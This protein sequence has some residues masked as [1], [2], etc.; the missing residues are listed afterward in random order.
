MTF[1]HSLFA[2]MARAS[3]IDV[4]EIQG[5]S[6]RNQR[7]IKKLREKKAMHSD[8][9]NMLR[10]EVKEHHATRSHLLSALSSVQNELEQHKSSGTLKDIHESVLA[11]LELAKTLD[12]DKKVLESQV[13]LLR[14]KKII[15]KKLAHR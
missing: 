2:S 3:H 1:T 10:Q 6:V 12:Q 14:L 7:R 15:E 13:R 5:V 11:A 4:P 9:A 8:L